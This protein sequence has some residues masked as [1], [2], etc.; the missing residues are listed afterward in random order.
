MILECKVPNSSTPDAFDIFSMASALES[1]QGENL[2]V[3]GYDIVDF[4]DQY[5]KVSD[6]VYL[7]FNSHLLFGRIL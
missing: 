4:Y 7:L 6:F 3:N 1:I 2:K 5:T